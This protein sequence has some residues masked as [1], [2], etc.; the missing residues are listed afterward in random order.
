MAG[1]KHANATTFQKGRSGN[2][3]GRSPKV[4]P[5]G[6]TLTQLARAKTA[7]ALAVLDELMKSKAVEPKDR[8]AAAIALLDRGWGKPGNMD[9]DG[10]DKPDLATT[11]AELIAK[12]PA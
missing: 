6:E 4:G 10:N 11:L 12:L 3:G 8:I 5:N 2:P 9:Q 1:P 7:E